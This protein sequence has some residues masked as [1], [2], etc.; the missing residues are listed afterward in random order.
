[1]NEAFISITFDG[2]YKETIKNVMP[3]LNQYNVPATFY[4][5]TQSIGEKLEN[6]EV[7]NHKELVEMA[8]DRKVEIGSH[9]VTHSL[10][11][12]GLFN[13]LLQRLSGQLQIKNFPYLIK[14][15]SL[16]R[17]KNITNDIESIKTQDIGV[18]DFI[19]EAID[20]KKILEKLLQKNIDSFAYP[21]G[22][23]NNKVKETLQKIGYTSARTTLPGINT[24]PIKD[25]FMLKSAVWTNK[26]SIQDGKQWIEEAQN[27]KGWLIETFH[28]V[29]DKTNLL[30]E[31]SFSVHTDTFREHLKYILEKKI[32]VATQFN[33]V[34]RLRETSLNL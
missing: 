1:M 16:Q 2:C 29:S 30:Q 8:K 32:T 23:F 20:S 34:S 3:I 19:Q 27:K 13:E 21:G 4:V 25:F 33:L 10:L 24:I 11:W 18:D 28:L 31:Y 17:F 14:K 6:R 7:I 22:R 9:S 5:V 26:N 15:M 12:V